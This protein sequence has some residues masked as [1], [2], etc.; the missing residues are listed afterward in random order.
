MSNPISSETPVD[1]SQHPDGLTSPAPVG[2]L[3]ATPRAGVL[4][5][6]VVGSLEKYALVG[7]F[8]LCVAVFSA[9]VPET[10]FT[11]TNAR[12]I[13]AN[14][15]VLA[16]AGLAAIVPL[17]GGHFDLS[18]G[19]SI[20]VSAIVA[21]ATV[22]N[23]GFPAPLAIVT[24]IVASCVIGVVNG[25]LVTRLR[26]NSLIATLG[27]SSVL[28]GGLAWYTK[29]TTISDG[30]PDQWQQFGT[31]QW[32][33]VPCLLYL[34]AAAGVILWYLMARTPFGRQLEAVGSN[35]KAAALVG[36]NVQRLT[37]ASF[38]LAGALAGVAGVMQVFRAASASPTA[39]PALLLPIVSAAFLGAT[40]I[41]PGKYNVLGTLV[42]V[43]FIGTTVSGLALSGVAFY[44]EQIFNGAALVLGVALS[45][46]FARHQQNV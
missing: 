11:M 5:A 25:L 6:P 4:P 18:L 41:R 37:V 29:G 43:Y 15:A 39:G 13:A 1:T 26:V 21:G 2:R 45:R 36:I 35:A 9:A 23:L 30:I 27:M 38:A 42:A 24:A 46:A 16:V 32:L 33:G 19:A 17:I 40:T 7:V 3:T 28:A 20:G 8:V 34:V 12:N 14:Q 31:G 44:V 10:F 22:G